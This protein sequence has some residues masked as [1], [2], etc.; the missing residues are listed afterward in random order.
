MLALK[1]SLLNREY[2]LINVLKALASVISMSESELLYDWRFTANQFVLA[3]S[4]LR[5]TTGD[6]FPQQNLCGH[7]LYVTSSLTRG[8]VCLL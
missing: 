4:P 6:F 8:R 7:S 1:G 5:F 3:P 2:I